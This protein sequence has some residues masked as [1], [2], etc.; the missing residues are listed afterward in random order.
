MGEPLPY[1]L[2]YREWLE[3]ALEDLRVA[4]TEAENAA[5]HHKPAGDKFRNIYMRL[6]T[7]ENEVERRL[8]RIDVTKTESAGGEQP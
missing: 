3:L 4:I 1:S 2:P 7:W 5:W 8:T 6:L